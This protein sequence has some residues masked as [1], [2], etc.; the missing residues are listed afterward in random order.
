MWVEV[1]GGE[2]LETMINPLTC[3]V[4]LEIQPL[5]QSLIYRMRLIVHA[6]HLIQ[7][8]ASVWYSVQDMQK[9]I[10]F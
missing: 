4:M 2:M 5:K 10:S 9:L 1:G 8:K 3:W 7:L 6:S